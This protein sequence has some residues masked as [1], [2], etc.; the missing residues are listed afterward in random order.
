MHGFGNRIRSVAAAWS[1]A[2]ELQRRL[3]IL[4]EADE[5]CGAH[6]ADLFDVQLSNG[7]ELRANSLAALSSAAY[8][9]AGRFCD[10]VDGGVSEEAPIYEG[11]TGVELFASDVAPLSGDKR[12]VAILRGATVP[13]TLVGRLSRAT[14]KQQSLEKARRIGMQEHLAEG[15]LR[16]AF[17]RALTPS[18]AVQQIMAP[19]IARIEAERAAATARSQ[20]LFLVG[21]HV[22]Q[23]DALDLAK[24]YFFHDL[25]GGTHSDSL[26]EAFAQEM[27]RV[28]ATAAAEGKRALFY[29]ASDQARARAILRERFGSSMVEVQM[30]ESD[31]IEPESGADDPDGRVGRGCRAM[32]LA[33]AEWMLLSRTELIIRSWK[34]SFSDEA[35]LVHGV[36][37][38]DLG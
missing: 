9:S 20:A 5:S 1:L 30:D 31:R 23:G 25:S 27:Q 37:C 2:A 7:G 19:A 26:V 15:K 14:S 35:S 29:V 6:L 12:R 33:V 28:V 38:I 32:Q 22:R 4:W 11:R 10:V 13:A 36:R 18:A 17:Y 24:R 3:H 34:S 21:V 16:G 8:Y